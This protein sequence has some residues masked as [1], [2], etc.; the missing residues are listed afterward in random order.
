MDSGKL[1]GYFHPVQLLASHPEHLPGGSDSGAPEP[2]GGLCGGLRLRLLRLQVEECPVRHF[3]C[4]LYGA[5]G[6]H[7]PAAVLPDQRYGTGEQSDGPD[8]AQHFQRPCY[9]P[10]YPVLPGDSQ[11][12][13][14]KENKF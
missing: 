6:L 7:R 9:V 13:A 11:E 10:V 4:L 1:Q 5:Y 2:D 14:G 8:S 3:H 12:P